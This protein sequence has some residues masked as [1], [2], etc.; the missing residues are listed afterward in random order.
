MWSRSS[1]LLRTP[2]DRAQHGDAV[3][4][5]DEPEW[6]HQEPERPRCVVCA[7]PHEQARPVARK[8]VQRQRP[9][10]VDVRASGEELLL[11]PCRRLRVVD[12]DRAAAP[13]VPDRAV[14]ECTGW[15]DVLGAEVRRVVGAVADEIPDRDVLVLGQEPVGALREGS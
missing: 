12:F 9:G 10:E 3:R 14:D 13:R 1:R 5:V 8:R 15:V 11:D 6:Q 2:G 4:C 7:R